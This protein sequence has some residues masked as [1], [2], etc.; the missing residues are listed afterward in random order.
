MKTPEQWGEAYFE[1]AQPVALVSS[2]RESRLAEL[3]RISGDQDARRI[4]LILCAFERITFTTEPK[5]PNNA[6]GFM[7][8]RIS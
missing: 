5:L 4:A 2:E 3:V 8:M 7:P 1:I 6:R